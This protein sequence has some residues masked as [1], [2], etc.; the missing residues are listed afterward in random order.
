[1]ICVEGNLLKQYQSV[2]L[3]MMDDVD[4]VCK[5]EKIKY[6][7]GGGSALGAVRHSGFIPW[8]DDIDV[9]I[10]EKDL[11]QFINAFNKKFGDKYWIHI[12]GKTKGYY[13]L[14]VQIR[15]KG[16]RVVEI[17]DD[18]KNEE[19]GVPLDVFP[20]EYTYD[21]PVLRGVH[22]FLS[23]FSKFVLSCSKLWKN[24]KTINRLF[25]GRRSKIIMVKEVLGFCFSLIPIDFQVKTAY[26]INKMCS[27]SGKYDVIPSGRKHFKGEIYPCDVFSETRYMPFEGECFLVTEKYDY[28][29]KKLYGDYMQIPPEAKREHHYLRG[30]QL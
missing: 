15:K 18:E 5:E 3:E 30:I 1:M 24:R 29:L 22:C 8:D 27:Q 28:Y 21:N 12:P 25:E 16:T 17:E 14:F 2:L 20:I 23:M 9:N 11:E 4:S 6:S 10:Y 7:L 19:L 26:R 13:F